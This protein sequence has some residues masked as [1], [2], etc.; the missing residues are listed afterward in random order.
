MLEHTLSA[1]EL[2]TRATGPESAQSLVPCLQGKEFNRLSCELDDASSLLTDASCAMT[3][4]WT[5]QAIARCS[6]MIAGAQALIDRARRRIEE[7][8]ATYV[9]ALQDPARDCAADQEHAEAQP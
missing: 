7:A 1:A 3:I 4:G 2:A 8:D 9:R 5:P 6:A